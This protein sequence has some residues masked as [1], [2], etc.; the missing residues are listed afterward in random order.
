MN[1]VVAVTFTAVGML[2]L[3]QRR[4]LAHAAAGVLFIVAGVLF[5]T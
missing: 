3:D 4:R 5:M 1:Y 2:L